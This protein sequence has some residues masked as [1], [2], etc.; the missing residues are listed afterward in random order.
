MEENC[1]SKN[2]KSNFIR[3]IAVTV[4]ALLYQIFSISVEDNIF[5]KSPET[6]M[7]VYIAC[8]ICSFVVTWVA[9]YTAFG[10]MNH[11]ESSLIWNIIK[12]SLPFAIVVIISILQKRTGSIYIG[13]EV[14]IY[15]GAI[16]IP[17]TSNGWLYYLTPWFYIISIMLVPC[18]MGPIIVKG[19]VQCLVVGYIML[20]TSQ[21]FKSKVYEK[22]HGFFGVGSFMILPFLLLPVYDHIS[23]VHRLPTYVYFW[24][25]LVSILLFD[26]LEDVKSIS[27]HKLMAIT[28]LC[29]VV[30]QWRVEGIYWLV[31]GPV[32]MFLTYKTVTVRGK[33]LELRSP[34]KVVAFLGLFFII[35]YIVQ[36]PQYGVFV[37]AK[38]PGVADSRMLPF[39]AHV[40]T[41]MYLY[42]INWEENAYDFSLIDE[43]M[44]LESIERAGEMY[45][46]LNLADTMI[47][48]VDW[49]LRHD[50]SPEAQ[51]HFYEAAKRIIIN[52]PVSFARTRIR[53]FN[54]TAV[55]KEG[56]IMKKV[57]YNLYIPFAIVTVFLLFSFF[58]RRWFSFFAM[59]GAL[60]NGFIVFVLSPAAYFKYYFPVYLIA[61]LYLFFMVVGLFYNAESGEKKEIIA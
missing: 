56:T 14:S 19:V 30:T 40:I 36:I 55:P 59:G 35:Q 13:D 8:R 57:Q 33:V 61:Y 10:G 2:R 3:C 5:T 41:N 54:Y 32:L 42:D 51:R 38:D 39:Y 50:A 48:F 53:T 43:Y 23:I 34:K 47:L 1:N 27:A 37:K 18:S 49:G 6:D 26:K 45:G 11:K 9:I 21:Y 17:D 12:I 52:N 31:L 29:A 60:A 28:L 22:S 58:K 15:Y 44:P 16:G 25:L 24:V 20:R 4:M 46:D 7:R